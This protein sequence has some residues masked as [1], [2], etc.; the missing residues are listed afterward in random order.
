MHWL[1]GRLNPNVTVTLSLTSHGPGGVWV[2]E[3]P[4]GCQGESPFVAELAHRPE[5]KRQTRRFTLSSTGI[6]WLDS[7]GLG[8]LQIEIVWEFNLRA[9]LMN[10]MSILP[11]LGDFSQKI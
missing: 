11:Y 3:Q 7:L 10:F 5:I 6:K 8:V 2:S 4:G 1:V 9:T